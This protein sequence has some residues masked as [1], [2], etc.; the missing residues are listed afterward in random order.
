MEKIYITVTIVVTQIISE[1]RINYV[2]SFQSS[3]Q[4]VV[5]IIIWQKAFSRKLLQYSGLEKGLED[6][7]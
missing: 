6:S 3:E 4:G 1:W 7:P 5:L 2:V